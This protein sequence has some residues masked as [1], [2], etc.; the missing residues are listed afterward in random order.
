MPRRLLV[1]ANGIV[2]H[3]INRAAHRV[4]LFG[5][6][7]DYAAF[8]RTL[9]EA[10]EREPSRLLAYAL[11]PNHWHLVLWPR[12]SELPSLMHWLTMTHAK[13][14]RERHESV[15]AG[16]V[17]QGRYRAIPV[18]SD[19]HLLALLRYVEAN[20]LRAGLVDRAERWRWSSLPARCGEISRI[21]LSP[22]PFECPPDWADLV[23]GTPQTDVDTVRHAIRL[24]A[25]L[26]GQTSGA[27]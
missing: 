19:H 23:N 24:N 27:S 22:W 6:A 14:W 25:P 13:R 20:A 3:V 18:E 15:G 1:H 21:P 17:Y 11:M 5:D 9:A 7:S 12:G 10:L 4:R 8:E 16:H 26:G 2:C